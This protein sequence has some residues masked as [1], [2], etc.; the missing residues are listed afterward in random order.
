MRRSLLLVLLAG[1]SSSNFDVTAGAESSTDDTALVE[2]IGGDTADSGVVDSEIADTTIVD[3]A[4]PPDTAEP[5][6]DCV[7]NACKGCSKLANEPGAAC[8]T[9]GAGVYACSGTDA[10]ACKELHTNKPGDKCGTCDGGAYACKGTALACVDPFT[11]PKPGDVCGVCG[12]GKYACSGVGVATCSDPFTGP[13]PTTACGTCGTLKRTCAADGKTAACPGDDANPC[14]GCTVLANP[15]GKMC[16]VC[17]GGA[18]ACSGKEATTCVDPVTTPA[19]GVACG[20]CGTSSYACTGTTATACTL[21]DDRKVGTDSFYT[22]LGGTVWTLT[23]A[24]PIGI[25]FT[26][27]RIG[28]VTSVTLGLMRHFFSADGAVGNVRV[29]L[30]RG[31]PN[32]AA[33]TVLDTA[34]VAASAIPEAP[35]AVTFSF[36]ATTSLAAS[37]PM[38]LEVSD[39]SA[40]YNFSL[41]GAGPSGPS[42]LSIWSRST[43]SSAWTEYTATDPYLTV[44]A[45]G[46]GF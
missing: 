26:T 37:E 46:C 36:T 27:Q 40:Q 33:F 1:C 29:R 11:G 34:T 41:I 21:P 31:A 12:A 5:R 7:L 44:G 24:S 25:S 2:E 22:S 6:D 19:P 17:A 32:A 43:P 39:D 23:D 30:I 15:P 42:H 28:T 20:T 10:V 14:G 45:R 9:C 8:G 4:A 38:F 35:T 18:Y 16:G 3:S 13:A